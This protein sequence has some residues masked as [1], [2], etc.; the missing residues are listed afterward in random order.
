MGGRGGGNAMLRTLKNTGG[1]KSCTT[2]HRS[3]SVHTQCLATTLALNTHANKNKNLIGAQDDTYHTLHHPWFTLTI[4]RL[5]VASV[6]REQKDLR[7]TAAIFATHVR[8]CTEMSKLHQHWS[9]EVPIHFQ[10]P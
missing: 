10:P 5:G 1:E 3:V 2:L 9:N 4:K 8:V 6:S 7:F